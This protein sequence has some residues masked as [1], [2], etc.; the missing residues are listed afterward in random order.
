VDRLVAASVD[1]RR[2]VATRV[3]LIAALPAD[4]QRAATARAELFELTGDRDDATATAAMAAIRAL[5][6]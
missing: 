1:R 3:A 4:D 2:D 6:R 5:N